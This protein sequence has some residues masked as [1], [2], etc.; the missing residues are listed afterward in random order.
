MS[1]CYFDHFWVLLITPIACSVRAKRM[2]ALHLSAATLLVVAVGL[3]LQLDVVHDPGGDAALLLSEV[4]ADAPA[5]M[6]R[7][8]MTMVMFRNS[9]KP[10]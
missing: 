4:L 7:K 1:S 2:L 10:K 3:G 5:V 8:T 9:Q 6:K